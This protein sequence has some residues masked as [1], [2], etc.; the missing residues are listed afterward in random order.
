MATASP[1]EIAHKLG[2]GLLSFPVTHFKNDHSFDEA[3]YRENIGW[4]GQFDASGLFAAGGTGE[5]FSLTPP[6]VEQ[7]V[8]AAV[9]EAPDGLPVIAP[10]G[11][12]TATAVQM[13]RSAES[14]GAHGILLLPPYLTEASQD[15]LVAHVKE[16]CAATT[17]GVTIYSRANAVYTEAAVAELADSCPNLVGFKDGVGNIEQMT[18]IYASLGDRL[19]YIGGLPTAEMFAL[20]YLALGVTTYSSA[21]YN[22]VPKFA[23]DFYN[24]LRS[25][26]NAF[27]INALNEFVI[28]YCNLRNKKQGYAVSIIKAGMTV[29]DRPAGPVRA[30]LTDLDAVELAEL[31]DLIKKVS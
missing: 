28:P 16:V 31:A 11:Y 18:R 1:H 29:I 2:S 19:T 25:G 10:A 13:A 6:E 4:L 30:P 9:Q 22:F 23:L 5:F 3:A 7:V 21:I 14:V 8:R 27:V 17:L 15:G 12:G 24:A 20:P 26:D